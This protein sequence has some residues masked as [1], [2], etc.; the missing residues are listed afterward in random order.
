LHIFAG[1]RRCE[2]RRRLQL[3]LLPLLGIVSACSLEMKNMCRS[4]R[5][6][7]LLHRRMRLRRGGVL[8]LCRL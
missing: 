8:L 5:V 6:L 7:L 4:V 1:R 3:E 2:R